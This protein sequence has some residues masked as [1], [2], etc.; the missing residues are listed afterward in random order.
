MFDAEYYREAMAKS[1]RRK[2]ERRE[3]ARIFAVENRSAAL[4]PPAVDL[5]SV[6]GLIDALDGL[7]VG[8][9]FVALAPL[10]RGFDL[11]RYESHVQAHI[12]PIAVSFDEIPS[13]GE[14]A[15]KDRVWRF[16]ALIFMAHAGLIA[17]CQEG[18]TI[19]V[20]AI[21]DRER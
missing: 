12:G 3:Q 16:V 13:L 5:E 11:K 14:D 1:R 20:N 6:P 10:C 21:A 8:P 15:R 18:Q 4:E 7:A 19:M 17:I 9:E 2:L